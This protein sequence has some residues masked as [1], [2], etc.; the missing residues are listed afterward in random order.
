MKAK[1]IIDILS[2]MNPES[3]VSLGI[4]RDEHLEEEYYEISCIIEYPE[5]IYS[6]STIQIKS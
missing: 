2:T 6:P 5:C 1:Y 4:I 3:E